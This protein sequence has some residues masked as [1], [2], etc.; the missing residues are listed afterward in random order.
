MA[1]PAI[2]PARLAHVVIK[3]KRYRELIDW[4]L[5]LLG[6]EIVHGNSTVT[7][8]TYDGEHH[9]LA[10]IHAPGLLASRWCSPS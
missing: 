5:N 8:M 7:F 9:R 1:E 3:T 10:I 4:Y 6:A 2:R